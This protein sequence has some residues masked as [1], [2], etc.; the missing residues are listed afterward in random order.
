MGEHC[1][2]FWELQARKEYFQGGQLP[3]DGHN[4]LIRNDLQQLNFLDVLRIKSVW[5][6]LNRVTVHEWF[7]RV[8]NAGLDG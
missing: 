8:C 1:T 6:K 2:V 7:E 4:L 3:Y 5:R